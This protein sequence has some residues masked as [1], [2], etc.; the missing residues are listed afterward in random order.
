MRTLYDSINSQNVDEG[1]FKNAVS[2][3]QLRKV[4]S[5][6]LL[7]GIM[8]MYDYICDGDDMDLFFQDMPLMER[9]LW[10][11]LYELYQKKVWSIIDFSSKTFDSSNLQHRSQN[12]GTNKNGSDI[13]DAEADLGI[14]TNSEVAKDIFIELHLEEN[15]L[16]K[17]TPQ[18]R[19]ALRNI[20]KQSKNPDIDLKPSEPDSILPI[21]DEQFDKGYFITLNRTTGLINR[22]FR[23]AD[24]KF[25]EKAFSKLG[26]DR[27]NGDAD[28]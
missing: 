19:R 4:S 20:I 9:T 27:E 5:Q 7:T 2:L 28:F 25:L 3:I 21:Y 26:D 12:I 18:F 17:V 14:K 1:L 6:D 23:K 15:E 16:T 8:S 10:K 13:D 24:H 22:L 11:N